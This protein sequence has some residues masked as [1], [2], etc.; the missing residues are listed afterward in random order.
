MEWSEEKDIILCQEVL[1]VE[2]FKAKE[3]T[4]QRAQLWQQIADNL[5]QRHSPKLKVVKRAVRDHLNQ[6]LVFTYS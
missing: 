4:A 6:F 5:N 3:R 2:P 1:N